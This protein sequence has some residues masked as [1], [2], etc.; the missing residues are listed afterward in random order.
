MISMKI[1]PVELHTPRLTIR[2]MTREDGRE[3]Y[4][5]LSLDEAVRYEPYEAQSEEE[6]IHLA[7]AREKSGGFWAVC[8]DGR[9]IGNLYF[10]RMTERLPGTW[11]MGYIFNPDFW[12]K[13]YATEAARAWMEYAF[14]TLKIRRILCFCDPE[15]TRSWRVM[16]RLG[17]RRRKRILRNVFFKIDP[18]GQPHWYDAYEYRMLRKTFLQQASQAV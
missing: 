1:D 17:M 3:L 11:E 2:P 5:Y 9:M 18:E 10:S 7:L 16:E 13:G 15:N 4:Q 6:C 14:T 12:G 8:L